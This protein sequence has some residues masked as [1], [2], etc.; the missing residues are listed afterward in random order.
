M[1]QPYR[2][3]QRAAAGPPSRDTSVRGWIKWHRRNDTQPV[4]IRNP[5]RFLNAYARSALDFFKSIDE[6]VSASQRRSPT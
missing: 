5:E 4:H 1:T 3:I 6:A 2:T